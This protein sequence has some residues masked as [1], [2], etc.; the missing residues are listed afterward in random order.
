MEYKNKEAAK[1][2]KAAS[3]ATQ[4]REGT[5]TDLDAVNEYLKQLDAMCIAKPETYAAR[6]AHRAAEI[7]GLQEA[8]SPPILIR[9]RW[10]SWMGF[11]GHR[12]GYGGFELRLL[13]FSF[14]FNPLS[15]LTKDN[16]MLAFYPYL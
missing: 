7:S 10:V 15:H 4:D 2:D 14:K 3:E 13:F 9:T 8:L 16:K 12:Y 11:G 5:Q 1:L 6:K